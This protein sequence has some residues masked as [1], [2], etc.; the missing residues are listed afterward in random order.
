MKMFGKVIAGTAMGIALLAFA[1]GANAATTKSLSVGVHPSTQSVK[2]TIN[3]RGGCHG[4]PSHGEGWVSVPGVTLN[5]G[6]RISVS[7]FNSG[8]CTG[9][10]TGSKS[11]ITVSSYPLPNTV[12]LSLT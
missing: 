5:G 10:A 3:G 8:N 7:A 12:Y 6:D 9:G 2:V 11:N 1:P 4:L